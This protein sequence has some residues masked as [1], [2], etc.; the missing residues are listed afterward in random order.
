MEAAP[1]HLIPDRCWLD[2]G[3]SSPVVHGAQAGDL[4]SY[5]TAKYVYKISGEHQASMVR[6][7]VMYGSAVFVVLLSGSTNLCD[8]PSSLSCRPGTQKL[9]CNLVFYSMVGLGWLTI[10]HFRPCVFSPLMLIRPRTPSRV[11]TLSRR[12]RVF[13]RCMALTPF[14]PGTWHNGQCEVYRQLRKICLVV[15]EH[16]GHWILEGGCA[17]VD[18]FTEYELV[19]GPTPTL[20]LTLTRTLTELVGQGE[21]GA[22]SP[23]EPG[24]SP[25][26]IEVR[27]VH[28]PL[29]ALQRMTHGTMDVGQRPSQQR[30]NG[31][32]LLLIACIAMGPCCMC[33][34]SNAIRKAPDQYHDSPFRL[35]PIRDHDGL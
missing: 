27:S 9:P 14:F 13:V 11:N 28:D 4:P 1:H 7:G 26:M 34:K 5:D 32:L 16:G 20:T 21:L 3:Q 33:L 17:S 30:Q 31:I 12:V 10:L 29:V 2:G 25:I 6:C 22:G 18:V 35:G 24:W 19:K 15:A 8:V 23:P